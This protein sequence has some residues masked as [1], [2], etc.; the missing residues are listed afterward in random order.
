MAAE[1]MVVRSASGVLFEMD[2]PAEGTMARERFDQQVAKGDLSLVADPVC[3]VEVPLGVDGKG[4]AMVAR[5]LVLAAP[6]GSDDESPAPVPEPTAPTEVELSADGL[7]PL[8]RDQLV[9]IARDAGIVTGNKGPAKLIDEILAVVAFAEAV[10]SGPV[11][12]EVVADQ[13]TASAVTED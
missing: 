4:N 8:T 1:T 2:V 5:K 12:A 13:S 3:W 9:R 10:E 11:P 7:A 6:A